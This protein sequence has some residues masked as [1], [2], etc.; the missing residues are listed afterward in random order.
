MQWNTKPLFQDEAWRLQVTPSNIDEVEHRFI[1]LAFDLTTL[2]ERHKE[3]ALSDWLDPE[4]DRDLL[5]DISLVDSNL[6]QLSRM[7]ESLRPNNIGN[8]DASSEQRGFWNLESAINWAN[9]NVLRMDIAEN[10]RQVLQRMDDHNLGELLEPPI[11]PS[12]INSI[13]EKFSEARQYQYGELVLSAVEYA[14]GEEM[15][16]YGPQ[17]TLFAL[18]FCFHLLAADSTAYQ[19]AGGL[20]KTV[21]TSRGVKHAASLNK[22]WGD[23][24]SSAAPI[25]DFSEVLQ[26]SGEDSSEA[27][28]A[29]ER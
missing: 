21:M 4:I 18:R 8:G 16:L 24:M 29:T 12:E 26:F 17:R 3:H 14:V 20:Y 2:Y 15:G 9:V 27:S 25:D 10:M 23:L 22:V 13:R 28:P 11:L 6:E 1:D 7:L 19:R 5:R